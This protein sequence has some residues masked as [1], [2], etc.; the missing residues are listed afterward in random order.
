MT[1]ST[2]KM[3]ELSPIHSGRKSFYGK[4]TVSVEPGRDILISYTTPVAEVLEDGTAR[5]FGHYS[6]TTGRHIREFLLQHGKRAQQW[7]QIE[8]DYMQV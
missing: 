1:N 7:S 4:A 3:Y 2:S 6:Q 5:V 8:R